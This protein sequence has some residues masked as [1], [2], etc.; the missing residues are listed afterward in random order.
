MPLGMPPYRSPSPPGGPGGFYQPLQPNRKVL[1]AGVAPVAKTVVYT[2]PR[3]AQVE[4]TSI[5]CHNYDGAT[6]SLSFYIN[7]DGGTDYIFHSEPMTTATSSN[8]ETLMAGMRLVAGAGWEL[9]LQASKATS[10][11]YLITGIEWLLPTGGGS[12]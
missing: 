5:H 6:Q 10:I 9:S 3:G 7:F 8:S 4:I 1:A 12:L 2:V 11:N